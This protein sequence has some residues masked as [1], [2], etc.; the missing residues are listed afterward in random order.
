M[1]FPL[2]QDLPGCPA[3]EPAARTGLLLAASSTAAP[4]TFVLWPPWPT[5]YGR[6]GTLIADSPAAIPDRI[7]RSS[8]RPQ[9]VSNAACYCLVYLSHRAAVGLRYS[10]RLDLGP[11]NS[12][13]FCC[14]QSGSPVPRST[15]TPGRSPAPPRAASS[16]RPLRGGFPLR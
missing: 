14:S 3:C 2:P 12:P 8:A 10:P 16:N 4:P 5:H 11:D 9:P 15:R 6:D 13:V 1:G 7:R